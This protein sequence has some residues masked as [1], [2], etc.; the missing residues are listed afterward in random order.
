MEHEIKAKIEALLFCFPEGIQTSHLSKLLCIGSK[1]HIKSAIL[2][3]KEDYKNRGAGLDIVEENGVWK[4]VVLDQY[5]NLIKESAQP[6]I[7]SALL[8]TLG[9]IAMKKSILQSKLSELKGPEIYPRVKEL[10]KLGLITAEK[11]GRTKR[12]KPSKKFYRYFELAEG[13]P[14]NLEQNE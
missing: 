10:V 4:F 8:E 14:I 11:K 5:Q 12:L 6:E 7:D 2:S 1:G 13:E 3:L 9:Y